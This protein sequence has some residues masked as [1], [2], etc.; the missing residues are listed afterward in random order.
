VLD[1]GLLLLQAAVAAVLGRL[2]HLIQA[3]QLF[4]AAATDQHHQ[5]LDL[6]S[7]TLEAAVQVQMLDL[8]VLVEL[9]AVVR[10]LLTIVAV[11]DRQVLQTRAVVVVVVVELTAQVALAALVL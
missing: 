7:P 1:R 10:V 4:Q 11:V 3:E 8:A 9:A 6:Q 5:L 2:A